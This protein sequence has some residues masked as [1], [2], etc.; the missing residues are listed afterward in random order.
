MAKII[1]NVQIKQAL[2]ELKIAL[3]KEHL[4]LEKEIKGKPLTRTRKEE[5]AL[6]DLT[7]F[8]RTVYKLDIGILDQ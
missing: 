3:K 4:R 5:R 2:D 8:I 7:Y 1:N 6:E